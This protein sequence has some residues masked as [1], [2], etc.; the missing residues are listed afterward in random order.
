MLNLQTGFRG[1]APILSSNGYIIE[2][3]AIYIYKAE[4]CLYKPARKEAMVSNTANN[5]HVS[6]STKHPPKYFTC[7]SLY[8]PP[9]IFP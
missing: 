1:D 2:T 4:M 9:I 8:N 6:L 5:T 7:I 3:Q